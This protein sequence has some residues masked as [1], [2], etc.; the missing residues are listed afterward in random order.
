[1]KLADG[2]IRIEP[3]DQ[4][5]NRT[6]FACGND[7]LDRYLREQASQDTRR[8]IARVFVAVEPSH[9]THIVGFFTL[10]AASVIAPELPPQV[11]KRLPLYPIPAALIG[12]LAVDH[13]FA[14]RGLA[15]S[16]SPTP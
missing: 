12:R 6:A 8:G 4:A 9:P 14:R 3:L 16:F 11:A 10:S 1:V 13:G 7:S 2:S 15:R 5:L